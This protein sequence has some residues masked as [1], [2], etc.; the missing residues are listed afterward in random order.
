MCKGG[1][2][3]KKITLLLALASVCVV[4]FGKTVSAKAANESSPP[5][6]IELTDIFQL[7]AGSNSILIPNA[8]GD[9]VQLTDALKN[10][11]GAVWSTPRNMMDLTHDFES[12]MYIYFGN[13]GTNAAD[14]MAFVMQNDPAGPNKIVQGDG[15]QLGVWDST[16]YD[17][18]DKGIRNSFAVEFDTHNNGNG[19]FDKQ[20]DDNDHIAWNFPGNRST[21][22]DYKDNLDWFK[23]KRF[24]S[25]NNPQYP[26]ELSVDKWIP[27][28]IKWSAQNQTL[29][30]QFNHMD[31]VTVS[32][33]TN[34]VFG[35]TNVYWGFTGSTGAQVEMNRLV[36][37]KVPGLVDASLK[38]TILDENGRDV[39]QT[40]V[41]SGQTLTYRLE[42]NY[43]SGKQD[44]KD[45]SASLELSEQVSFIPGTLRGKSTGGTEVP[46]PDSYWKD[47]LLE[48]DMGTMNRND[49]ESYLTFKAKVNSVS[50]P[51]QV[52]EHGVYSGKNHI[53]TSNFVEY[54]IATNIAPQIQLEHAGSTQQIL[55]GKDYQ[56]SGTWKDVDGTK[57]EIHFIV[58]GVETSVSSDT[59]TVDT[60]TSYKKTISA[61]DLKLGENLIDVYVVDESGTSSNHEQLT[62]QTLLAPTVSLNDAGTTVNLEVGT[63]YKLEG[64]WRDQDSPKADLY[65]EI[66]GNVLGPFSEE[67]PN[68]GSENTFTYSIDSD[69]LNVGKH[70][71]NVYS[72]DSEQNKSNT[73]SLTINVYGTLAFTQVSPTVS[74]K[75]TE[76]PLTKKIVQ[77]NEDWDIRVKDTRGVGG[78]WHLDMTLA[79]EF[80]DIDRPLNYLAD[81][82]IYKRGETETTIVPGVSETVYTNQTTGIT[83][84][85]ISWSDNEGVLIQVN[86][87]SMIGTYEGTLNWTLVDGP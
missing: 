72:I 27:F 40:T 10:Q 69:Y 1:R 85:P 64:T 43:L 16:N 52:S 78:S 32:I 59:S 20:V 37:E 83:E 30:Y 13:Q 15:A 21:Y 14:G 22:N 63:P 39:H 76:V 24:L 11:N 74:F 81:G 51:T 23:K 75:T 82:L 31:P 29:T 60:W 8:D 12:S 47:K 28:N 62:I 87:A 35:S 6:H 61:S 50:A 36:F 86:A 46:L 67:N 65:Y 56:L 5:P 38:K 42:G 48:V 7:P 45:I 77:R 84:V 44:W 73:E 70:T 41:N 2:R 66:D 9:I 17:T 57:G 80:S 18:W 34:T 68:L 54:E 79:S 33:D 71:L 55:Y 25:H 26:G 4:T 3:V 58:N 19:G 53:E 49:N